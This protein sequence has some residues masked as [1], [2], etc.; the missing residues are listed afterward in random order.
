MSIEEWVAGTGPKQR[1]LEELQ[2]EADAWESIGLFTESFYLFAWR[3][4]EV[5]NGNA[6]YRFPNLERIR[7]TGGV[8]FVRNHFIQ[9]PEKKEKTSLRILW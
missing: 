9:H 6:E 2:H 4:I 3:L 7:T 1:S 8:G 5:L